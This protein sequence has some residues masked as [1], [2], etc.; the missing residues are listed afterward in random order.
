MV[1]IKLP[2]IIALSGCCLSWL[3]QAKAETTTLAVAP[4]FSETKNARDRAIN[5]AADTILVFL[6][7]PKSYQTTKVLWMKVVVAIQVLGEVRGIEQVDSLIKL[8]GVQIPPPTYLRMS[9]PDEFAASTCLRDAFV[10]IGR[11]ASLEIISA[12]RKCAVRE[13]SFPEAADI[14][15]RIEGKKHAKALLNEELNDCTDAGKIRIDKLILAT[16]KIP[17]EK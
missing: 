17:K 3:N 5:A 7:D 10:K 15:V 11:N 14:L 13:S 16:E 1:T 12:C 8:I 2:T 9:D 4:S 6:N